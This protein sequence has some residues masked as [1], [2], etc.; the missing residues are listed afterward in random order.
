MVDS[1]D[2]GVYAR[3]VESR[4]E[5]QAADDR[6]LY[7]GSASKY[8]F[9]LSG[10]IAEHTRRTRPIH[11]SRLQREIKNNDLKG[12][13]CFITLMTMKL[14]NPKKEAVL[15]VRRTVA[16]TEAILTVWLGAI[17][18]PSRDLERLYP[19]ETE[20]LAYSGLSSHNPLLVDIV[21]PRDDTTSDNH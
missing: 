13:D 10:R 21:E 15:D 17:K 2:A 20:F 11:Q 7:I 12:G 8:G 19:W 16:L 18:S 4:F 9:G 14:N 6:H 5:I 1:N 3:L